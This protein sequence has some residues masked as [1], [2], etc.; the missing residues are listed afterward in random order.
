MAEKTSFI[1]L[2]ENGLVCW[3]P[4]L[5]AGRFVFRFGS[6]EIVEFKRGAVLMLI[7]H[8]DTLINN[9]MSQINVFVSAP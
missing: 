4:V 7:V 3:S 5:C 6:Y 2:L 8:G 1:F 9:A